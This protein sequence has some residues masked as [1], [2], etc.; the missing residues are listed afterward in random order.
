MKQAAKK[1]ITKRLTRKL[2]KLIESHKLTVIAVTGTVGKTS[3]KVA[4]A[5]VLEAC[6]YRVGYTD[7]SYNTEIGLPLSVF[8]LKVPD[9]LG[10]L[11]EWR[12]I[13]IEIDRKIEDFPYDVLVQEVAEDDL[14]LMLPFVKLIKPSIG[15]VTGVSL[16]HTA[17]MQDIGKI[18]SGLQALTRHTGRL[19]CNA[20]FEELLGE[21]FNPEAT[22]AT[23][24]EADFSLLSVKRSAA[25]TLV[26]KVNIAG[27]EVEVKTRYVG[28]HSI[29]A[30]LAAAAVASKLDVAPADIAKGL[31]AVT[32]VKGRMNLL[33]GVHGST[34]IDDSY[35]AASPIG[36]FAALDTLAEMKGNKIAVLGNM[37]EL[38]A[39]SEG[40][41]REVGI[42]AAKVADL[43]VVIGPD[44]EKYLAPSAIEAGM[45]RSRVK[46]FHTP[47]EA[48][49]YLKKKVAKGDVVLVKGSQNKVFAEEVSRILLDPKLNPADVLVRQSD[50]W[51][52]KKKRAFAQ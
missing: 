10:N 15:V 35:N 38:G 45:D 43:L 51:K 36:V 13:F 40:A 3:T 21:G 24:K 42:A 31:S 4:T 33:P 30:M 41:H 39:K 28:R 20:D 50:F 23:L 17:H 8:G 29:A 34:L 6:G 48:G 49:H 37:N 19:I 44:A 5:Q 16:A 32:P 14:G 7:D 2:H 27:N 22:Y 9:R 12:R 52:R 47:Y 46:V 1:L 26:A 18:I 25:G 11:R